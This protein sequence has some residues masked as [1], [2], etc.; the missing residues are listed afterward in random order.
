MGDEPAIRT[1][2]NPVRKRLVIG[3]ARE[4]SER[5]SVY[6]ARKGQTMDL[7][8]C[9]TCKHAWRN[10][11]DPAAPG[12][13]VECL[14]G[15]KDREPPD[16]RRIDVQEAAAR[17]RVHQIAAADVTCVRANTRAELVRGLLLARGMRCA[18]VVD[19]EGKLIGLVAKSD[20]MRE[21][22]ELSHR[23]A[24]EIMTT[25]V[26]ALP[27][28]APLA[29]AVSLMALEGV[30]EVPVVTAEGHVVGLVTAHEIVQWLAKQLW[31][32]VPA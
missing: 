6:C 30:L 4:P 22:E 26:H 28:E 8:T 32:V 23:V 15:P 2:K 27:E 16:P 12:A 25:H 13:V 5:Y 7:A 20:L 14:P 17:A 18:P 29:F 31:Y 3:G 9:K 19:D 11:L 10:P 21:P 24:E 1:K